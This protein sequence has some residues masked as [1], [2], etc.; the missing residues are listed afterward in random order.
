MG[1]DSEMMSCVQP[2]GLGRDLHDFPDGRHLLPYL[3][4]IEI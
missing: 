3:V 4:V 1:F 2:L